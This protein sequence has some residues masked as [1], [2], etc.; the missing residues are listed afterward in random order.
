M[1]KR[2]ERGQAM[3][4]TA[5]ILPVFCL[6]LVGVLDFGRILYS[7]AHL[8]M[9]AQETVRLAGLGKSDQDVSTFAHQYVT[10]GDTSKLLIDFNHPDTDRHSGDYVTVTLTYPYKFIT[11][12]ISKLFPASFVIKTSSTTRVE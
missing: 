2:D 11:P 6:I 7:Y 5:L 8:Q 4:E 10:L 9:A 3:V 1:M 12:M